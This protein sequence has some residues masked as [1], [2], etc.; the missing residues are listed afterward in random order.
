MLLPRLDCTA[1]HQGVG[2]IVQLHFMVLTASFFQP[3]AAAIR[4]TLGLHKKL[5]L[6]RVQQL[7]GNSTFCRHPFN[8]IIILC[9]G[10]Y[11]PKKLLRVT[12]LGSSA[13]KP[14]ST[15]RTLIPTLTFLQSYGTIS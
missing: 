7:A 11:R 12:K 9:T 5:D 14:S 3:K 10:M 6:G 13:R 15:I 2:N 1:A 4:T 8:V